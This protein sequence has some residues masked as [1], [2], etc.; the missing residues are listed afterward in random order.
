MPRLSF[1][2][3]LLATLLLANK[4][5]VL[6]A[7][8]AD[9]SKEPFVV[10]SLKTEAVC[11]ADG[12]GVEE[13]F[14]RIRIQSDAALKE[15]G[16]LRFPYNSAFE[17]LEIVEAAVKKADGRVITTPESDLQDLQSDSARLAPSFSDARTKEMPVR[18]LGVGDTLQWHVRKTRTAAQ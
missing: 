12:T 3:A 5:I 4:T 2:F 17:R 13:R 10:E 7:Q 1:R 8:N 11:S 16:V 18:G 15:F 14:A 6:F 9:Y